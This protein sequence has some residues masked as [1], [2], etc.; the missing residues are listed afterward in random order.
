MVKKLSLVTAFF[1]ILASFL[2][3]VTS[4]QMVSDDEEKYAEYYR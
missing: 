2:S 1:I 4:S 3:C